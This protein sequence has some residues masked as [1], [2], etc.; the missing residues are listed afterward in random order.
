MPIEYAKKG[1]K[2]KKQPA[3]TALLPKTLIMGKEVS[4]GDKVTLEVVH[5]YED[6]VEVAYPTKTVKEESDEQLDAMAEEEMPVAPP[7]AVA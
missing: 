7:P 2:P 6:E 1:E 4:P 3:E 5:V